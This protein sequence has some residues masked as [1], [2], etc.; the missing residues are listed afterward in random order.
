[1]IPAF[2]SVF[3]F[4][5]KTLLRG[6]VCRPRFCIFQLCRQFSLAKGRRRKHKQQ[7]KKSSWGT[8]KTTK[9]GKVMNPTDAYR[10]ELRKKELKRV[11]FHV[12]VIE[13][14][15]ASTQKVHAHLHAS[16]CP[17]YAFLHYQ[18]LCKQSSV[19]CWS[20]LKVNFLQWHSP[21]YRGVDG[22]QNKKE[23]KKVREVGI[24]KKDPDAIKEQIRKLEMMSV[25]PFPFPGFF[26]PSLPL[27]L[28]ASEAI[29]RRRRK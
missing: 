14:F 4:S 11:S 21:V 5:K 22:L 8:M 7:K 25:W 29:A 18:D 3:F 1:M 17:E 6:F 9:G 24:L 16:A 15:L 13:L 26:K 12:V 19:S 20:Q 10:K 23:R 2:V 28:S 27:I